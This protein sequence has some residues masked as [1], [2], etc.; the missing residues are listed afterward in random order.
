MF[1]KKVFCRVPSN[2]IE[3]HRSLIEL[4]A[5][6]IEVLEL[7]PRSTSKHIEVC[8][9]RSPAATRNFHAAARACARDALHR[10][11]C[12]GIKDDVAPL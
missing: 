2:H 10:A 7:F 5:G 8:P 3:A 9:T 1:P 4:A 6:S 12:A 11:R